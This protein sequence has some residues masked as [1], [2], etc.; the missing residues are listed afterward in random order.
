MYAFS[1]YD[2]IFQALCNGIYKSCLHRAVVNNKT[3][4]KSLAFFLS[5]NKDRVVTPPTSLIDAD[6]PRLYPDFTWPALLEFTQNYYR[7][8][9][10]TLDAFVDRIKQKIGDEKK[11][12][13]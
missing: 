9:S 7:V 6:S 11:D 1:I 4:R 13:N 3:V 2:V 12:G 10:S 5:P 8:D